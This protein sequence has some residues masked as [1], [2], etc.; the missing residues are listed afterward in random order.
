MRQLDAYRRS[1]AEAYEEVLAAVRRATRSEPTGRPAKS[2]SS[3]VEK[4][5]RE[6]IRLSQ[7]QDIAGCRLVVKDVR[8]QNEVVE[9]LREA[10]PE[11]LVVDRRAKPSHGYRAV[12]A[13]AT[14]HG[15]PIEIQ[16]RTE[17]QHLWAQLSEKLSDVIDPA[18]KYGGGGPETRRRLDVFSRLIG[19]VEAAELSPSGLEGDP[20]LSP[21][22]WELR[23]SL[24]ETIATLPD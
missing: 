13:I 15:K 12:H 21:L 24:E 6:T 8:A 5:C 22:K 11:A 17:L 2:T 19:T 20:I 18:I 9:Q 3:I 1:F 10:L 4:L 7:M 14:A 23:R 16:V